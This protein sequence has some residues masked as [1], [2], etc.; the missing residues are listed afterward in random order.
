MKIL[1]GKEMIVS[2]NSQAI[3]VNVGGVLRDVPYNSH[4]YGKC[5]YAD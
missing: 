5:T 4:L 3:A 1:V 2:I